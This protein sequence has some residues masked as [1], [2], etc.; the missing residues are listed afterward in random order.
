MSSASLPLTCSNCEAH[1]L[2]VGRAHRADVAVGG[3]HEAWAEEAGEAGVGLRVALPAHDRRKGQGCTHG[4][5]LVLEGVAREVAF[6]PVYVRAEARVKI[7][8]IRLEDRPSRGA[9]KAS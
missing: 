8:S 9:W 7:G 3:G 5:V 4:H 2:Q 6:H 1:D